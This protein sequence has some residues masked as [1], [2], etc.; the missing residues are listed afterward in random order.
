[1]TRA[2]LEKSPEECRGGSAAGAPSDSGAPLGKLV[3]RIRRCV[4]PA[5]LE[6]FSI[7]FLLLFTEMALIRWIPGQV[8]ILAYFSSL[9]LV[10]AFLGT[11]VGCIA[12]TRRDLM[13]LFPLLLLTLLILVWHIG[14]SGVRN[15]SEGYFFRLGTDVYPWT[16]AVM[17]VFVVVGLT[18]VPLGQ[19]LA[20]RMAEQAPL[21]GYSANLVGSLLGTAV[22]AFLSYLEIPPAAWFAAATLTGLLHVW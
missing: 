7:S 22:F 11:G 20:H 16:V 14:Q 1:M 15:P 4:S 13:S 6:V 9:V 12:R 2:H 3:P 18:F 17:L 10:A 21:A 19:R 8:R 5:A